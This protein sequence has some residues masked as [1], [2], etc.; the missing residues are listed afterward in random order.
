[1][2]KRLEHKNIVHLLTITT[3]PLQL[4]SEWMP[5]GGLTD[6]IGKHPDANR[7][8]LVGIRPFM[9]DSVLTPAPG[10]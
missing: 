5:G 3:D 8:G 7:F 10:M 9:F 1:M 2:W 6:F 4:I